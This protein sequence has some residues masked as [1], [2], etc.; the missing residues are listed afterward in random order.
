[1]TDPEATALVFY[2]TK[3][4]A[5]DQA[6]R[7]Q[8]CCRTLDL[9]P[10]TVGQI[11]G[12]VKMHHR[13]AIIA[14][15]RIVIMTPDVCHAWLMRR[16]TAHTIRKYLSNLA[17]VIIDEAHTYESVFGSNSAYLFRRLVTATTNAANPGMPQFIAATATILKPEEHLEKLT[18]QPFAVI[19]E[20][21][22]GSPRYP[23]TLHH[24]PAVTQ[25]VSREQQLADLIISII[26]ND[27]DAQVI[28]FSDSRQAVER[29][30]QLV[31]R[32]D[33]VMPYRAGYLPQER[34]IIEDRLR[35]N[36]IRAVIATSALEL[37]IDM[38][39]LNYGINL[40]LPPSR[41]QFHQRLGRVG[42]SRP[43]AFIVL[44]PA[45]RFSAHG[46]TLR[47]YFENSVEPSHLYLENEYITFQQA[48]C[49]KA[50]ADDFDQVTRVP[51]S[52]CRWPDGF[53]DALKNSHGPAPLHLANLA[54]RSGR[55]PPQLAYSLRS[56]GEEEI[57]IIP[58]AQD[59]TEQSIGNINISAAINEAYPGAVY[60][61]RGDSYRIEEWARRGDTRQPF[62][63][64]AHIGQSP[65]RTDPAIRQVATIEPG[66]DQI[67]SQRHRAG[68]TG[69]I[70]QVRVLIT[71]S[72]E[73]FEENTVPRSKYG[74][75][76][77]QYYHDLKE[78]DPRKTRK[79]HQ[80]PTTAV[81][82]R[83]NEPWFTGNSGAPGYARQQIARV[84]RE[85]L[86]YR[87]SIALPDL[88]SNVDSVIIGT[89]RG[90]HASN[91][92]I[93]VY[94]NIYGGLG[95]VQD[96]YENLADY[97]ARLTSPA[98]SSRNAR[99]PFFQENANHLAQWLRDLKDAAGGPAAQP[100]QDDWWRTIRPESTVT[101]YSPRLNDMTEGTV[102]APT[103]NQGIYYQIEAGTELI[104]ATDRQ[105][106]PDSG[107]EH[108]W[109]LWQPSSGQYREL[110][111]N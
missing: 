53:D 58:A 61:H 88:G 7:W 73:G 86:A 41:K 65:T 57:D 90:Y 100:D 92:S 72:V 11:D 24:L 3:A 50:E 31:N 32:P 20:A 42:R 21:V 18:G 17:V 37:G 107:P 91:N 81:H 9:P 15:S 85:L 16:A 82:L 8:Q 83:V 79:Q 2:P 19:S 67:I 23:R 62:I 105:V 89:P 45:D 87:R 54:Q 95:L 108:D 74:Q 6:Q 14:N 64:A 80:F 103:W 5:N 30:V 77:V 60:R 84:L 78:K 10:D 13:D 97:V 27:S 71:R 56:T 70:S 94:D 69:S 25:G 98:A 12:D 47:E 109:L 35:D 39:D 43:G 48:L 111:V 93:V 33:S 104:T 4:L 99:D 63:R 1:M 52:H 55:K 75:P 40:D 44:A 29:M 28:A 106:T 51:P 49:L 59:Q 101:L 68:P 34:R 26:D 38:P 96:L 22:N 66:Q 110:P 102:Q 36:S 46:D 76:P